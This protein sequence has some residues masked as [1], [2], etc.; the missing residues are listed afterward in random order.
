MLSRIHGPAI[1]DT[2]VPEGIN[3]RVE[4]LRS[5][6][7][8]ANIE[9]ELLVVQIAEQ[10]RCL[11]YVPEI[12]QGI[13]SFCLSAEAAGT[14]IN[15]RRPTRSA[16]FGMWPRKNIPMQPPIASET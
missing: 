14:G 10:K 16:N 8:A 6:I 15:H 7:G 2:P 9:R 1:F 11:I 4:A 13:K 5:R 3:I 12:E